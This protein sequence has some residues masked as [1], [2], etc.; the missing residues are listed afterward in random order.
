[1]EKKRGVL[2]LEDRAYIIQHTTDQT[3][4]E[5]AQA[6]NRTVEPIQKFVDE[7]YLEHR[8]MSAE[9]EVFARLK[10]KLST[11]PYYDE[12]REQLTSSE[13]EYFIKMW[14]ETIHQFREDVLPTEEM[15]IK[16]YLILEVLMNRSMK[17][18]K[19]HLDD[20]EKIERELERLY[21]VPIENRDVG[22][23]DS[24][25][26][27]MTFLRNAIG[28]YTTEHTK[29][30]GDAQKISK[31]LKATR[32]QRIKIVESSKDTWAKYLR[33]L[34]NEEERERA[35]HEI[36][37]MK[38]AKEK[39]KEDLNEWHKYMDGGVDLP[40]L[41]AETYEKRMAKDQELRN[42]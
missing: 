19:K 12:I 26:T 10:R 9:E 17:E 34:E 18:R 21:K 36:E 20:L 28:S 33:L 30:S 41:N 39:V 14:A 25:E 3:V 37:L 40:I 4:A 6:L 15:Q 5:M 8:G 22:R 7:Q 42:E 35:G 27:R 1:M 32:D 16:Q 38:L 31:D 13:L 29:L 11:R 24:L 23:I 2:S